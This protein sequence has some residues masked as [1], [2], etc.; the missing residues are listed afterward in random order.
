MDGVFHR[1]LHEV[2]VLDA[3]AP[4]S[5]LRTPD[6]PTPLPAHD[7][8]RALVNPAILIG[9]D[10]QPVRQKMDKLLIFVLW[11]RA[12]PAEHIPRELA[13]RAAR[14][15]FAIWSLPARVGWPRS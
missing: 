4:G 6:M 11:L 12:V 13:S 7:L 2:L 3:S 15:R 1:Y 10:S 8:R 14:L 5:R 9:S